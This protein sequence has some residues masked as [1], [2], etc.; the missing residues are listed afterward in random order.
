MD[1]DGA[2]AVEGAVHVVG[3]DALVAADHEGVEVLRL[4]LSH[5]PI[6]RG[7]ESFFKR[8]YAPSHFRSLSVSFNG[9]SVRSVDST[10]QKLP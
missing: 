1:R 9:T 8:G 10:R 6:V 4:S 3:G 7:W 2:G 5:A